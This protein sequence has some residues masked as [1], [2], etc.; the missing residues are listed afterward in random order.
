MMLHCK[1]YSLAH[2]GN[3]EKRLMASAYKCIVEVCRAGHTLE[4]NIPIC[5]LF[6]SD[7]LESSD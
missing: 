2:T 4:K 5:I 1:L 7:D 6:Y 3:L